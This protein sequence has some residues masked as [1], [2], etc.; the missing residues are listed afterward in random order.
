VKAGTAEAR[1]KP[2]MMR[3]KVAAACAVL[4]AACCIS[5]CVKN[6][7]IGSA[8][9]RPA[10]DGGRIPPVAP[11]PGTAADLA[12]L[13]LPLYP[14]IDPHAASVT[15]KDDARSQAITLVAWTHDEFLHVVGWYANRL[16][17][18]FMFRRTS[19]AGSP[20]A[21]FTISREHGNAGVVLWSRKDPK[22][23]GPAVQ[24]TLL[25]TTTR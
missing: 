19:F 2:G 20:I 13:D 16:G 12:G 10:A 11:R 4:L 14:G 9:S 24:I 21:A 18:G 6:T 23:G 22:T 17:R 5:G 3:V 8:D 7:N 25:A 1:T 15:R